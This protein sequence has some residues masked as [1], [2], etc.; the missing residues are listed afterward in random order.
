MKRNSNSSNQGGNASRGKNDL[1]TAR[2][3]ILL[4]FGMVRASVANGARGQSAY[5]FV[6]RLSD[7][8]EHE[9]HILSEFRVLPSRF[10]CTLVRTDRTSAGELGR[11][12]LH[13]RTIRTKPIRMTRGCVKVRTGFE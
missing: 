2:A 7:P 10:T 4:H 8:D 12:F 9:D 3:S 5:R 13:L 11:K 6:R 1:C